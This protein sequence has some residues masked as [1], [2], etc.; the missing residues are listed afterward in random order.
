MRKVIRKTI[1][2]IAI[3]SIFATGCVDSN[4]ATETNGKASVS[5]ETDTKTNT[6]TNTE[7]LAEGIQETVVQTSME[8]YEGTQIILSDTEITV[9]GAVITQDQTAAVYVGADMEYYKADQGENYGEGSEDEAH[10]EE[11]ALANAIVTIT[12]PGTYVVSGT[13]SNGQLVVDLG[14]D[15]KEDERAVVNVTLNG[16]NINCDIASAI[17]VRNV[18]ECG[19]DD[20]DTAAMTVDTTAAGFNLLIAD[21][22]VNTVTGSHVAKVYKEGTTAEEIAA[23]EAKKAYKYDAAIESMMSLNINGGTKGDGQLTVNADNEGIESKL[24]MTING[25]VITVNANDDSINAGEDGVSVITINGGIITCD[26]GS[27]DGDEGDGIDSNGWIVING[28][29]VI[30]CANARSM[31]SGVDSDM[32]VYINGGTV[33]ASG[34]MYDEI[35]SDSEQLFVVLSFLEDVTE[36]EII[37]LKD[38]E[39]NPISAF[40]AVNAYSIMIYSCPELVEGDYTLYQVDTVTGDLKGSIYT[41]ITGA[42]NEVQLQYTS[43][44]MGRSGMGGFAGANGGQR[45]DGAADHTMKETMER[46]EGE[47]NETRPE[48]PEGEM[49]G[50]KSEGMP[51]GMPEDVEAG[52]ENAGTASTDGAQTIFAINT[53]SYQFAGIGAVE[54]K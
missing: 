22:S 51:A 31:D 18:Y 52:E 26:S 7:T 20:V 40:E 13:L 8:T 29:Y 14:E 9:D 35:S 39:D 24:H 38:S 54:T 12:Q 5:A 1:M 11:E 48:R 21:G 42:A 6:K 34:H 28:G 17:L 46:P 43:S 36:D 33:L 23:G 27:G 2:T 25:G 50:T 45:P 15:A 49:N 4:S 30:A 47:M 41:D 44:S 16:V 53:D 19:S 3:A 32:G 37:L 10:S